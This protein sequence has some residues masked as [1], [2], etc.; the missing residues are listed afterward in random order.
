M[1]GVEIYNSKNRHITLGSSKEKKFSLHIFQM[2]SEDPVEEFMNEFK[3]GQF[4]SNLTSKQRISGLKI[5]RKNRLAFS[6]GGER[7][8]QIRGHDI[9]LYLDLQ[10]PYPPILRR[11]P[12]PAVLETRREI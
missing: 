7:L 4:S 5:H 8:G 1:Y 10:R 12:Y 11:P 9:E 6:I 3:E 2:S